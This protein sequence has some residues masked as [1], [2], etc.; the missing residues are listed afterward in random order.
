MKKIGTYVIYGLSFI[1]LMLG[2]AFGTLA[3]KELGF[4]LVF[5][6]GYLFTFLA[7]I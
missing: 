3:F 5:V 1:F 2:F 4:S 6:P 7:S